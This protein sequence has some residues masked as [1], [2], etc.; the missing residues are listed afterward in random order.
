MKIAI[1]SKGRYLYSTQSLL[2]AC[3]KRQ[4]E[5]DILDYSR[6]RMCLQSG[7]NLLEY[8]NFSLDDLTG[9]IPRIGHPQTQISSY[10]LDFF[11]QKN[12]V[13]TISSYGLLLSRD[14]FRSLMKLQF[15]HL[16]IPN[17]I[18][19]EQYGSLIGVVEELGGYPVVLKTN[20]GTHGEGVFLI[21]NK[22][23]LQRQVQIFRSRNEL[24][25]LQEYIAESKGR[26]L[27]VFVVG[28]EVVA[29]M[30]RKSAQGSFKANLHQ[31][32]TAT[33][34]S[35]QTEIQEIAIKAAKIMGLS[36]AGVDILISKTGAKILEVNAS[37]GLEGIEKATQIDV[38]GQIIE[39][40][41]PQM[42]TD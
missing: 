28:G 7:N 21:K 26:D 15:H 19:P 30:E 39:W 5:V 33:A 1:L 2:K 22:R 9:I 20:G 37:P 42:S 12:I 27:R 11:E 17:S 31:G 23:E 35:I 14:K 25:F 24:F 16:P 34:I 38:A 18:F 29:V 4:I 10:I 36:V 6:F 40:M 32:G 3:Q 41:I 8:L 13:S